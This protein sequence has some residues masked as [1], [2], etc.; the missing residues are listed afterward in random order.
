MTLAAQTLAAQTLAAQ[1]LAL[2]ALPDDLAAYDAALLIGPKERLEA[3]ARL[4][5]QLAPHAAALAA[6]LADLP[7]APKGG[8]AQTYLALTEGARPTRL[9]FAALPTLATRMNAPARPDEASKAAARLT[10][11]KGRTL[12]ALC[13][14]ALDHAEPLTAAVARALPLVSFKSGPRR[15]A[16]D[17]AVW[18]EGEEA[19]GALDLDALAA[20][21][22][23]VQR[24]AA[25]VDTPPEQLHVPQL[26]DLAREVA[27]RAGAEVDVFEGEE[28]MHMG[29]G[30]VWAVGKAA[31]HPPAVVVLR[32]P[33]STPGAPPCVWVGKGV[34]YDCGGLSLKPKEGMEGMKM[35]MGGAAA[36]LAAFDAAAALGRH[37]DLCAVLCLAENA[38]GPA[39]FR[40]DDVITLYSGKTVEI[41]NTDAEGRLLLGDGVAYACRHLRPALVVDVATLT[42]AQLMATGKA[43]AGVV[44]NDAR[45]EALAVRLGRASGDLVHPL[46]YCP[47]LLMGEFK[48]EV[49]DMKNSVRDRMNAQSSCAAHFVEAHLPEGFEGQWLHVDIAGPA[50]VGGRG[51]G[52]GVALLCALSGAWR[53]ALA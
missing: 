30:G 7:A 27:V 18:L 3:L 6:P 23:G 25:W 22:A 31:V 40:N 16:V 34:V 10:P 4:H 49:A 37:E 20:L 19:Q 8:D 14:A 50:W 35:D 28:L 11:P 9:I 39:A 42:G 46:P 5:P 24:A 17:L 51:T 47:E 44:A 36:V 13:P 38:I 21:A 53:E 29:L 32:G 45:I 52:F 26:V 43:H 2:C 33:Q 1:T 41:N 48:S 12:I 15:P